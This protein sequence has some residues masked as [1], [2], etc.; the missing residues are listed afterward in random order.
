M[1]RDAWRRVWP[2]YLCVVLTFPLGMLWVE[3]RPLRGPTS[4]TIRLWTGLD[5]PSCG[6]TRA[7]RAMGRLQVAEAFGYNP[8]GPAVFS[9][10][11]AG[12]IAALLML[13]T[14][15]RLPIP[16]WWTRWQW[17]LL[18]LA[19]GIYLVVGLGRMCYEVRHPVRAAIQAVAAPAP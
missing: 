6:M 13:G 12:W 4:C 19:L 17:R 1:S 18:L 9:V 10:A 8:C 14:G 5:C 15:G 7:F 16:A 11:C 2:L 3:S